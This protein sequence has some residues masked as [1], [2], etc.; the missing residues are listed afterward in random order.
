[1]V[2]TGR[3]APCPC[4]S[5]LKYKK[6]CLARLEPGHDQA[7]SRLR[8][9]YDRLE[10][11]LLSFMQKMLGRDGF[12]EAFDEFM[13][14]PEEE[15]D[16]ALV[17]RQGPL[18]ISWLL[19]NWVYDPQDFSKKLSLPPGS[20]IAG[21]MRKKEAN[22]LDD[23]EIELIEAI[24]GKPF[25]FFEV[26]RC[27]P[28]EGFL[29][30]DVLM[31]EETEVLERQ[32]SRIAKVGDILFCRVVLIRDMGL[33]Y[34][35]SS[36]MIP[37]D[38]KPVIIDLRKWLKKN[39]KKITKRMLAE[40]DFD[41]RE[42]YLYISQSLFRLP[43]LTNT[44]GDPMNIHTIHYEIDS[45]DMAFTHLADLCVTQAA[46]QLRARADLDAE[47]GMLR[48]EIPW[49]RKGFK[50]NAGLENTLLG[51]L[52]IEGRHLRVN[53][54]SA[55]RA[56][57]IRREIETRLGRGARYKN[58]VIESTEYMMREFR[59]KGRE[60]ESAAPDHDELMAHPEVRAKLSAMISA[61]WESWMN[62]KLPA[63]GGKTPRQAVKSAD[64]REC[65][66]A[67]LLSAER[68]AD[69][70]RHM[71]QEIHRLLREV[72]RKLGLTA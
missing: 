9:A 23:M 40:Y 36:Y 71:G 28:G 61:H 44:D 4:G 19:F 67:L 48:V 43:V 63:L 20:T 12:Q 52:V 72:R 59:E 62:E 33:V 70:D 42:A 60:S 69:Q 29:L 46:E 65:V 13:A 10:G 15:S 18:F 21:C 8:E 64:G 30:K 49:D 35:C 14:W 31:G 66:A 37:P 57:I 1:M 56:E 55:Q 34:G 47:G 41:I 39:Q 32:G 7:W 45:A 3:N 16:E 17:D 22:R 50:N 68:D 25:S 26:I 24:S 38:R 51:S 11:R 58:T 54:N 27:D 53:V 2:E 5:G 6:C